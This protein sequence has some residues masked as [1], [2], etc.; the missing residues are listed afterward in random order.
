MIRLK[1]LKENVSNEIVINKS[2]FIT[3]LIKVY[4][5][6]EVK[7][8]LEN[9][10]KKYP[11][12]NHYCYAYIIDSTSKNSDDKEPAKTAGM[13]IFNVLVNNDLN[14]VLAVVIRYF[15]GVKLGTGGLVRAYTNSIVE[16]LNKSDLM[17]LVDGKKIVI[18]FEF[19][20]IKTIDNLL[21]EFEITKN[22]DEFVTYEF[23]ISDDDYETIKDKLNNYCLEIRIKNGVKI[24]KQ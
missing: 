21:K 1:T 22:F 17:S 7:L 16:C 9:L 2:R 6:E 15:G 8:H 14:Y 18:E 23:L 5:E 20:K 12:A 24:E 11:N 13:P 4:N 3:E 19:S 10:R